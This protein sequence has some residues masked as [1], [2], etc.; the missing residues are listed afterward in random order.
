MWKS[1]FCK[2]S[3]DRV[4]IKF[5]LTSNW[6]WWWK[7]KSNKEELILEKTPKE[8]K[9]RDIKKY[10]SIVLPA[11]KIEIWCYFL[12]ATLGICFWSMVVTTPVTAQLSLLEDNGG[13]SQNSA[14]TSH[15][16]TSC[17]W[18]DSIVSNTYWFITCLLTLAH[19]FYGV[20]SIPFCTLCFN[21]KNSI[22]LHLTQINQYITTDLWLSPFLG[23]SF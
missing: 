5:S 8:K 14:H 11:L 16:L 3:R 10:R 7:S 15:I 19:C 12:S 17:D 13:L 22:H 1:T 9:G 4:K 2:L 20:H 21:Y 23:T 6:S 18:I